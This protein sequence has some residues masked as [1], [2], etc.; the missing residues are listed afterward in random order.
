MK[1]EFLMERI[2]EMLKKATEEEL[3]TIFQYIRTLL[4]G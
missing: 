2:A 1:K 3:R 4:Y